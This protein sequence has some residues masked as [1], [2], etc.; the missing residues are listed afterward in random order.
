MATWIDVPI[1]LFLVGVTFY[2]GMLAS[3][4]TSLEDWRKDVTAKFD[5]IHEAIRDVEQLV[6]KGRK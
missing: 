6:I 3:R 1:A 4:V 5:A 2:A